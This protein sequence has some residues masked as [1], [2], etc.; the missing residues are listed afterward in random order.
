MSRAI[1]LRTT[2][3]V[4]LLALFAFAPL[5][6]GR[7]VDWETCAF[8]LVVS[9]AAL[10]WLAGGG[11]LLPTD[12]GR[13]DSRLVLALLAS[14]VV[15]GWTVYL[16]DS[17][18]SLSLLGAGLLTFSLARSCLA[19]RMWN[20]IAWWCLVGGAVAAGLWGLREYVRNAFIMGDASWRAFGP[21]YNPNCLGGYMAL[22]LLAS[23]ALAVG[24]QTR[25]RAEQEAHPKARGKRKRQEPDEPPPRYAEI[26]G[27]SAAVVIAL[28]LLCTGSKGGMLAAFASVLIFAALGAERGT[29]LGAIL[30]W[31]AV[32]AV[33]LALVAAVAFPPIRNRVVAAFTYQQ[34][35]GSFRLHTWRGTM[36]MIAVRSL[37]GFGPGTFAHAYP[38]YARAGFTRQAHQTPLQLAAENGV[39]AAGLLML[40]IIGALW[41]I[42]R[43]AARMSGAKRLLAAAA[44]SGAVG[45]LVHN[46]VDYTWYVVAPSVAFWAM[47][48]LG[49]PAVSPPAEIEPRSEARQRWVLA[50][51]IIIV[52]LLSTAALY[53]EAELSLGRRLARVGALDLAEAHLQRVLRIDAH[54][55]V[56]LSRIYEHRGAR[57]DPEALHKAKRFRIMATQ[58]QPTEPTHYRAL[59]RICSSITALSSDDWLAKGEIWLRQGVEVYPTSTGMLAD[60]GRVQEQM[61]NRKEALETYRRLIALYDTPVRTCQA[62]E[63]FVDESY[64]YGWVALAQDAQARGDRQRA[65]EF[66]GK[67]LR[68]AVAFVKS[69]RVHRQMLEVAGRYDPQRITEVEGL[70]E[71]AI[72]VLR[73]LGEP[74]AML[75]IGLA[76]QGL[77][78]PQEAAEALAALCGDL[79]KEHL[80]SGM[81]V[82]AYAKLTLA[83]CLAAIDDAAEA[84]AVRSQ[85]LALAM[86]V[87][88]RLGEK[89]A[90]GPSG[91]DREDTAGLQEA[92]AVAGE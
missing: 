6:L 61:G 56:E 78:R 48:G 50:P 47:L 24:A 82:L 38:R 68:T 37:T 9:A 26:A 80:V 36:D 55:W 49:W 40:G 76:L 13:S 69:Q 52:L 64:A 66:A 60:L 33:G 42:G 11:R 27:A 71:Q 34:H 67:G 39:I 51:I 73:G 54:R 7:L 75:R 90:A 25:A 17:L 57:G 5:C 18:L 35:S 19:E 46:L 58:W 72:E 22:L 44:V 85:G 4:L 62:V 74:L 32:A 59:G 3:R 21:F 8:L 2:A 70:A 16:Y 92:V 91:W 87:L 43:G 30:R 12:W 84:E 79:E 28:A 86:Q 14:I 45:L 63:Y 31:G 65:M 29:R 15:T 41:R 20:R 10:L 83:E 77:E 23:V 89:P 53:S 88:P 81:A 1:A